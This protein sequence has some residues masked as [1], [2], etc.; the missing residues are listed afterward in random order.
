MPI[1]VPVSFATSRMSPRDA[2]V[3]LSRWRV[4]PHRAAMMEAAV[5]LP[6]PGG[7]KKIME[8]ITPFDTMRRRIPS[9]PKRW[10]WPTIPSKSVGRTRS[11]KGERTDIIE[12]F[13][14]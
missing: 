4:L 8:G 2:V 7:P 5:V 1:M 12:A 6:H 14:A 3:A 10:R 13:R 9:G 11:A